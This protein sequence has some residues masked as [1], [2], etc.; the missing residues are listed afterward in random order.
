MKPILTAVL[1]LSLA[2]CATLKPTADFSPKAVAEA[3]ND[4]IQWVRYDALKPTGHQQWIVF[5]VKMDPTNGSIGDVLGAYANDAMDCMKKAQQISRDNTKPSRPLAE[6]RVCRQ[7][8][9]DG[10]PVEEFKIDEEGKM[11]PQDRG[12]P[13]TKKD[14]SI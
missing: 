8:H 12:D 14:N 6:V 13:D 7:F 5:K 11:L 3:R 1:A 4:D 2:A 10:T 9:A